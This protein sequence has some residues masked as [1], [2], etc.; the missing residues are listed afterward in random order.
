MKRQIWFDDSSNIGQA[1]YS[2]ADQTLVVQFK[3][4]KLYRYRNVQQHQFAALCAA[5]SAGSFMQ[6]IIRN[7]KAYPVE[8]LSEGYV[9]G[10]SPEDRMRSALELIATMPEHDPK[11]VADSV[12]N[13]RRARDAAREALS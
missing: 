9:A 8:K 1:A 12:H 11:L 13:Y 10:D 3:G 5:E 4:G 2:S 6:S 7:P